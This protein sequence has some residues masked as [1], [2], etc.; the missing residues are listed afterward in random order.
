MNEQLEWITSVVPMIKWD[1]SFRDTA[2]CALFPVAEATILQDLPEAGFGSE[3]LT[4]SQSLPFRIISLS[5]I[6]HEEPDGHMDHVEFVFYHR[7]SDNTYF[8]IAPVGA[9]QLFGEIYSP[10]LDRSAL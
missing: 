3:E 10:M 7:L 1:T 4:A 2:S 9:T 5:M 8:I 6:E